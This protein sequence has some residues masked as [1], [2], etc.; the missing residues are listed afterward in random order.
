MLRS[1]RRRICGGHRS[2]VR[3]L[4]RRAAVCLLAL[5]FLLAGLP[6]Q[7]AAEH[8]GQV[9]F[10]GLPVPGATVTATQADKRFVAITDPRGVYAFT[11]L[12]DGV[13]TFHVEMLGF[14]TETRDI[15][16]GSDAPSPVWEL[17]LLPFEEIT[18][19]SLPASAASADKTQTT[20]PAISPSRNTQASLAPPAAKPR[21]FQRA[22]V[23]ASGSTAAPQ[24]N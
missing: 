13:W 17:K 4:Q 10:G 5:G 22:E 7:A 15:I 3:Q 19:A 1:L 18:H 24:T 6:G 23:N 2:G 14:A 8:H 16:I 9:I 20:S 12:E 11:D 21:E